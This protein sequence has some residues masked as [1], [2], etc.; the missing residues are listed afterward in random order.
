M[1]RFARLMALAL[2]AAPCFGASAVPT[3]STQST[4]VNVAASSAS[5]PSTGSLVVTVDGLDAQTF[6]EGKIDELKDLAQAS[7]SPPDVSFGSP[8][9]VPAG[10]SQ[11]RWVLPFSVAS[12]PAGVT[13]T[14]YVAFKLGHAD[15]ALS[16]QLS[17]PAATATTWSL[18]PPPAAARTF[19]TD[20]KDE[21][22][23]I[24]I[25]VT[26]NA[27][28]T[29]VRLAPF[30]LIE[31]GAKRP[32][33]NG[34]WSLCK[35]KNAACAGQEITLLHGGLHNLW[36]MPGA[37]A[38][39]PPGKYEG[40][41]T[42]ASSDK[43]AGE[44]A[45]LTLYVSSWTWRIGGFVAIA[46]G[47]GLAWYFTTFVRQRLARDQMLVGAVMLR[48]GLDRVESALR[49]I[50]PP[51][52]T[53]DIDR[54]IS[55]VDEA[56]SDPQLESQGLPPAVPSPWPGTN[57]AAMVDTYKKHIEAQTAWI[58]ALQTLVSEGVVRLAQLRRD[59]EAVNGPLT[60]T[61]E[62]AFDDA[63][64][65]LDALAK[66]AAPPISAT[67]T[68]AIDAE[69]KTF[70]TAL[71][72]AGRAVG[73]STG[74]SQPRSL[75]ELRVRIAQSSLVAWGFLGAVTALVG[76]QV[77]VLSNPGFGTVTDF[78]GCVLWG[79]GLP[80]GAA[81]AGATTGSVATSFNIA[82]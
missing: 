39:V 34:Q 43:P 21:G 26:G 62:R 81:L 20:A 77:L 63:L 73:R 25:A 35:T 51:V 78:V 6:G 48:A 57:G 31:Q 82:R 3:P 72:G 42:I 2:Y 27:P 76:A 15:W 17:S 9:P 38:D 64:G 29:G 13:V 18:K 79:L 44:S 41:I 65:R 50:S 75:Q 14:R 60:P 19:M 59:D 24:S 45:S 33:A 56:L 52:N 68:A 1:S 66:Q 80:T 40:T 30:D 32:L 58:N 22:I 36:V 47:I 10:A 16:Y 28:V 70:S 71:S 37:V 74:S 69:I 12:M 5:A 23:P 61:E 7:S 53:P 67:L 8:V 46:V 11:R 55:A 49:T 4:V 54:R